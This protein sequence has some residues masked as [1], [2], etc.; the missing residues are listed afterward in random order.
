MVGLTSSNPSSQVYPER[1]NSRRGYFIRQLHAL[2]I[3]A[4]II[5]NR[6]SGV[7]YICINN[8]STTLSFLGSQ[9]YSP[10]RSYRQGMAITYCQDNMHRLL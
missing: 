6:G 4:P 8:L 3:L 5:C 2:C 10:I 9:D 7:N 1:Y